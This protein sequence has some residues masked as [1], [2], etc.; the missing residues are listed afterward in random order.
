MVWGQ[1]AEAP[2]YSR[3]EIQGVIETLED[4]AARDKL[5]RQLQVMAEAQKASS[6]EKAEVQTAVAQLLQEISARVEAVTSTVLEVTGVINQI[7]MGID[8]LKLQVSEPENRQFWKDVFIN[9]AVVVALGYVAFFISRRFLQRPRRA[10]RE[11]EVVSPWSKALRLCGRLLLDLLPVAIFAVGVYITLGLLNPLQKTRVV[12]L[13]WINAF[14]INQAV[15]TLGRAAFAASAPTLRLPSLGDETAH[16]LEIWTKR[17]AGLI[18]YGYAALQVA[19]LLGAPISFYEVL[20]RLL[21]LLVAVMLIVLVLQNRKE[22]GTSLR[23]LAHRERNGERP[24]LRHTLEQA[25]R[26][27]H[28]LA[29]LYIVLFYGVWALEI[30]GGAFYLL[31]GS[32]L[33]FLAIGAGGFLLRAVRSAFS[34]SLKVGDDLKERFPGLE[35][36]ANRYVNLV[37]KSLRLVILILVA[38]AVLQAWGADT[39]GW[40][41]SAP[42]RVLLGTLLTIGGILL[43]AYIVWEAS[44]AYIERYLNAKAEDGAT[45]LYSARTRTLMAVI[46]K[47]LMI[48]LVVVTALMVLS[49]LGVNIGPLLAGAGVLGLAIGFG[50]QKLVQDI[51]TGVFILLEDQIS[52]G[53]VVSVGGKAGLVEAVSIRTLRLRDLKGTVHTIPYSA[54]DSVSNLTK[55]FSFYLFEVGIAYREDVDEVMAVLKEIGADL[56]QDAEYGAQILEPLEVLGVDA[57]ADSAVV[58]KARIKTRPVKQ[59]WVGREFNR[60]MKKKFDELDIEIPFPHQTLYF[61]IDKDQTAPPAN[62]RVLSRGAAQALEES[63]E[64]PAEDHAPVEPSTTPSPEADESDR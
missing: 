45:Q 3:E 5:V 55:E 47:A 2:K 23:N 57:F 49:E 28:I 32:L 27:W 59:W 24:F 38:L 13:T 4:P 21:G 44:N 42:G 43:I 61:G 30:P 64:K 52:E 14:I 17:L 60:R 50:S 10:L 39:F 34:R 58:I 11:K 46:R 18:I 8:W 40:L 31:K 6:A 16:Y 15:I 26:I 48:V 37:Q 12:V 25:G 51:I 35:E 33:S 22:V 36:R 9:I 56:Q 41:A 29:V 53:D 62:V 1:N 20:L 7:P 63:E 19:L 54:I